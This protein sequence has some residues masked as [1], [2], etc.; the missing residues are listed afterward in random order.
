M[1]CNPIVLV[2]PGGPCEPVVQAK[3]LFGYRSLAENVK[4][5]IDIVPAHVV[6]DKM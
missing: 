4:N 6:L 5:I 1:P 2:C 3:L